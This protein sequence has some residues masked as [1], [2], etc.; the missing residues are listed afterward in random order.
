MLLL[1]TWQGSGQ[2]TK[3]QSIYYFKTSGQRLFTG[4][5]QKCVNKMF[6][7]EEK[8]TVSTV[9]LFFLFVFT[10]CAAPKW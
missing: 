10:A 9:K 1:Q 8:V 6:S 4:L 7:E 3:Y 2:T 5:V